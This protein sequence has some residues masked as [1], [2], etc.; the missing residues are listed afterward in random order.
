[1]KTCTYHG[2]KVGDID[3]TLTAEVSH[4]PDEPI[5]WH[6]LWDTPSQVFINALAGVTSREDYLKVVDIIFGNMRE[7]YEDQQ[8][9]E[10][11]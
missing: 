9:R 10:V 7:Q 4:W 5:Q 2:F 8:E 6:F 11:R 3:I 1:M